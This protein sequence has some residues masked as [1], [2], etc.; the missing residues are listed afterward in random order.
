MNFVPLHVYS[1][2][3]MLRSGLKVPQI[4]ALANKY[5]YYGV[6]ISDYQSLS[7]FPELTHLIKGSSL[8]PVYGLD[9]SV[10]DCLLSLYV[11]EEE[12][13]RNLIAL[14]LLATSGQLTHQALLEHNGGLTAILSVDH[15]PIH[16]LYLKGEAEVAAWLLKFQ[17]GFKSFY[18]GLPYLPGEPGLNEFVRHFVEKYPYDTIA[19]PHYLY[20]KEDDAIVL[21]IVNAIASNASLSEK[22]AKGTCY[23]LSE[24]QLLAYY[25]P[26]EIF[27]TRLIA[28]RS[29]FAFIAK[30]GGL[31]HFPN[32]L[33]ISSEDYLKKLANEG[34]AKRVPN[35]GPEYQSRLD[36]ELGVIDK[37]GYADYF[38][39]VQDYVNYAKTHDIYVGPGRGSGAGSLVSFALNI[40]TPD[41]LKHDLLF[42]RFLN[43]ERQSMPDIDV[44]FADIKR[45]QVVDYLIAKYG[46]RRVARIIT[47]QGIGAK[48]SLRD[49]GRVYGYE[50]REIDM[51][52]DLIVDPFWSLRDAYKKNPKFKELVD[53]DKYYLDIVRLA[54]K[55]EGLPRQAGLHAAGVVLNDEPLDTAI[56]VYREEGIGFVVGYE[57]NY[58]EEQGFLKMDLLGLR[59]LT[60]IEE[61]LTFIAEDGG[62]KLDYLTLPYEDPE[63]IALIASGRTMGLFQLESPGMKRAIQTIQPTSFDDVVALLAL[64][65]PGPMQNIPSFA[66]RKHGQ[67]KV[68]YLSPELE[69]ILKSTYGIIVYQEQIMQ[70]VRVMAG[71]SYGEADL[72]RRA[73]SK[74]DAHKLQL[75]K[76]DFIKG[77]LA[78]GHSLALANQAF[79]LIDKFANYGFNK[80]HALG[81]AVLTCQ[82]A[83]LKL[84]YPNAFYAAILDNTGSGD[85]KFNQI[86][87]E[88]KKQSIALALPSINKASDH[89]LVQDAHLIFPLTAIKGIQSNFVGA[90]LEDRRLHGNYA[91][92]FDFA[93]RLKPFG[94]NLVTLVKLI[95]AGCF[96]G[97]G[98]TR[99]SL[100]PI[101]AAAIDY[102]DMLY[103]PNG[104][105]ALL[106]LHMPKP[107]ITPLPDDLLENLNAEHDALGLMI[108]GSPLSLH[109]AALST[110]NA[111]PLSE[112]A[113]GQGTFTV[114]G[115]IK[116]LRVITTKR[117]QP[118]AFMSLY[119][120]TSEADF[121]IFSEEYNASYSALKTEAAVAVKCHKD[122]RKEGAYL[123]DSVTL[124]P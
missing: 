34:L 88:V 113:T 80:S 23:F 17:A 42:E 124:L 31:L 12:G 76:D 58:L 49:I 54:S 33:G 78:K 24:E 40:D 120:D 117:G 104:Q 18:L 71:F 29:H 43:P 85:S 13:Y 27:N 110:L 7:A 109:K 99:A 25:Q 121:I 103:G 119:D 87:S 41:P 86:I 89:F 39:I 16:A 102:A 116:S 26:Q 84:H 61:T 79:A 37:M 3:S 112:I 55:I 20:A 57:M 101:A 44:D 8:L 52:A 28:E 21:E 15:S 72:F 96:D 118:M 1:G 35:Y 77:C 81:Y 63:A 73:I 97:L 94:L 74:K 36:Y 83:Y 14:N 95:D 98:S 68:S 46:E 69:P 115:I 38:L 105:Q 50:T 48:Q 82:M 111:L 90:I 53:S 9:V 47:L 67:E 114:A 60:I 107:Q 64:F 10:E 59:N 5:H 91:D 30:R 65:R 122:L 70:I 62:P 106:D 56:P 100:R 22:E 75:L 6:G 19:F 66:A 123:A 51:I 2:C 11:N 45:D 92:I 4:L 108:S 32:D 93:L